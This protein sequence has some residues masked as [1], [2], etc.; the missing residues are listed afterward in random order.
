[1]ARA[2]LTCGRESPPASPLPPSGASAHA[3]HDTPSVLAASSPA[4]PAKVQQLRFSF[5]STSD[6]TA[7]AVRHPHRKESLWRGSASVER[8]T[9]LACALDRPRALGCGRHRWRVRR[10]PCRCRAARA[11]GGPAHRRHA[12]KGGEQAARAQRPP[13]LTGAW[14]RVTRRAS[15]RIPPFCPHVRA[16]K[17][18]SPLGTTWELCRGR[19]GSS[20]LCARA[21][22]RWMRSLAHADS[23]CGTLDRPRI[24]VIDLQD[25]V[26]TDIT[27]SAT[28]QRGGSAAVRLNHPA[29]I[30]PG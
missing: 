25:I 9:A 14:G 28:G 11:E 26:A 20:R 29:E 13:R 18:R 27:Q 24:L 19:K 7:L 4:P 3:E 23:V 17:P 2:V 21:D 1:M 15:R 22:A 12:H 16:E 10:A 6:P 8:A 5:G 30:S